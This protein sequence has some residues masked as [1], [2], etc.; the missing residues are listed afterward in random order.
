[1]RHF[2]GPKKYWS[3]FDWF[4]PNDPDAQAR[5]RAALT[6]TSKLTLF[7]NFVPDFSVGPK[8]KQKPVATTAVRKKAK[9]SPF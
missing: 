7:P 3:N 1:V 4:A 8:P 5:S 6:K 2:A 9:S